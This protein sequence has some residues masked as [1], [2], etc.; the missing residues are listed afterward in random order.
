MAEYLDEEAETGTDRQ[1]EE[2][3]SPWK[4][5]SE[6]RA[7][8]GLDTSE[9]GQALQDVLLKFTVILQQ[10]R[11]SWYDAAKRL[12]ARERIDASRERRCAACREEIV[13]LRLKVA[14]AEAEAAG[15]RAGEA[16]GNDHGYQRYVTGVGGDV[17]KL[18]VM[19]V[20]T[21]LVA[22]VVSS[23]AVAPRSAG[24]PEPKSG[25]GAGAGAGSV[26]GKSP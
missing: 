1:Q 23:R 8:E 26:E 18:V 13:A 24:V 21:A 9:A 20:I 14:S 25:T 2:P 15:R 6:I 17:I 19:T 16:V 5:I 10:L 22:L 11:R 7:I 3:E 4:E 12:S